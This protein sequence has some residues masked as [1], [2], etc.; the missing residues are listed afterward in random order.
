MAMARSTA[1]GAG[2][3]TATSCSTPASTSCSTSI[4][5]RLVDAYQP[6]LDDMQDELD[7]LEEEAAV[8]PQ[9]ELLPRIAL[10]KRELLNLRRGDRPAARGAGPAHARRGAVHPRIH[11]HLPARRARPRDPRRRE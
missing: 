10:K 1:Q 6:I 7:E 8:D 4:L 5:D 2:A 9:P 11:A 3:P